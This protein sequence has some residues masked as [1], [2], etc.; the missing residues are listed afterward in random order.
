MLIILDLGANDGCSILK[1]QNLL[2]DSKKKFKIYSFEPNFFFKEKLDK[3]KEN[4]K[5]VEIFYKVIGTK[6]CS[7]KLYLSQKDNDGSS[8]YSDKITNKINKSLFIECEEVDIVEFLHN[9]PQ[10]DE[11]WIKMD[12]EGAEYNIITHLYNNN[13]ISKI[14]KLFIEWHYKKIPSISE[15]THNKVYNMVKNIKIFSWD[16]LD[17]SEKTNESKEKYKTF[18]N[19][20]K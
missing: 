7:T 12:I 18:L 15:K 3:I 16:A 5:N 4:N 11:L 13:C 8:I 14:D 9:L 1:F 6:N 17:Y 19:S 20:I 2:K 10:H